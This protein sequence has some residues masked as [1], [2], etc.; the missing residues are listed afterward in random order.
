MKLSVNILHYLGPNSDCQEER[1][2]S[3]LKI[4]GNVDT[5]DTERPRVLSPAGQFK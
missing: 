5:P 1:F 3:V 2:I 4:V